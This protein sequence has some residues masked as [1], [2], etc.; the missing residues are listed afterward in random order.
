MAVATLAFV[1]AGLVLPWLAAEL[2]GHYYQP[3]ILALTHTLTLGWIT[4]TILGASY[5]L[6][7]I[8]LERPVWSERLGRL[9]VAAESDDRLLVVSTDGTIEADLPLPGGQQEGLALDDAGSLW[10][11]DERSGLL[12][13]D[14]ALRA[15]EAAVGDGVAQGARP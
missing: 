1:L 5:Q 3:H 14:G 8:L 7:P 10:V 6:I 9:L 12:R 15:L 13:F 4:L 2:A 11:A